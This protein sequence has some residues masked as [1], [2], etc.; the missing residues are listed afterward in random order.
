MKDFLWFRLHYCLCYCD[1]KVFAFFFSALIYFF[2]FRSP[3]SVLIFSLF[4][5]FTLRY[6]QKICN[7]IELIWFFYF[8]CLA[9]ISRALSLAGILANTNFQEKN[10]AC[11]FVTYL[12]HF[13]L[14]F[15]SRFSSPLSLFS[16]NSAL[17]VMFQYFQ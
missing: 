7:I 3:L 17:C 8:S 2:F 9:P 1:W 14:L 10:F 6:T 15:F 4:I 13:R 5:A 12:F 11:S 16:L